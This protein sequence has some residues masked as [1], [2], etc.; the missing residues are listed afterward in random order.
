MSQLIILLLILCLIFSFLGA[1]MVY[2]IVYDEY[3][4]HYTD[5]KRPRLIAFHQA[6]FAFFVVFTLVFISMV[7]FM[8]TLT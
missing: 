4:H 3:S 7:L 2:L 6:L 8:R 5:K 1:M